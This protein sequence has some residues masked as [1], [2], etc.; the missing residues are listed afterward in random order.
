[1]C[2]G[3]FQVLDISLAEHPGLLSCHHIVTVL[4]EHPCQISWNHLIKI[5]LDSELLLSNFELCGKTVPCISPLLFINFE[6]LKL[7]FGNETAKAPRG[8][9]NEA[10]IMSAHDSR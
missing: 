9:G 6:L 3:I 8:M 5:E 10:E 4:T 1:L 7:L 2:T